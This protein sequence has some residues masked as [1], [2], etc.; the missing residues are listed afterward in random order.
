MPFP[1]VKNE[2][3]N[4]AYHKKKA[5]NH[6]SK[7]HWEMYKKS[8]KKVNTNIRKTKSEYYVNKIRDG[9]KLKI[10]KKLFFNNSL[11][12][13]NCKSTYIDELKINNNVITD[14]TLISESLTISLIS[15]QKWP[16]KLRPSKSLT[17]SSH[18]LTTKMSR[19]K[20]VFIFISKYKFSFLPDRSLQRLSDLEES[21]SQ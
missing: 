11:L 5:T 3:R 16:T 4:R 7:H 6:N 12:G 10:L 18:R 1:S 8:R 19:L 9:A 2:M 17:D 15:A 20:I 14:S 21:E 13:K